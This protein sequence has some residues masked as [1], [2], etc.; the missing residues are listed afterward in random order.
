MSHAAIA[1]EELSPVEQQQFQLWTA[2]IQ[3]IANKSTSASLARKPPRLTIVPLTQGAT[4]HHASTTGDKFMISPD[5]LPACADL[6]HYF[7]AHELG[8]AE[9]RHPLITAASPVI[10]AAP[11]GYLSIATQHLG[12]IGPVG[13]G[14]G[15]VM[16]AASAITMLAY[17]RTMVF[18][19]DADRRGAR[20]IGEQNMLAGIALAKGLRAPASSAFYDNKRDR[21]MGKRPSLWKPKD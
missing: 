18:E 6:R 16:L 14:I 2:D 10:G 4:T 17:A 1:I 8:H 21:L 3:A 15:S 12:G 13:F 7:I 9:G 20:M 11:F 5:L 19:W